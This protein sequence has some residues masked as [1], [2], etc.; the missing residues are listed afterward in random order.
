MKSNHPQDIYA[1]TIPKP[2]NKGIGQLPH[3]IDCGEYK[4]EPMIYA[5][6]GGKTAHCKK[7][8]LKMDPE[9]ELFPVHIKHKGMLVKEAIEILNKHVSKDQTGQLLLF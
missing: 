3:C 1:E 5:G 9:S 8:L 7:C 2:R 4:D 6:L